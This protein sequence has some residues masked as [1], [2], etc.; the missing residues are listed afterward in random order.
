MTYRILDDFRIEKKVPLDLIDTYR[1]KIPK[2]FRI[3]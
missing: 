2:R 3:Y 1:N